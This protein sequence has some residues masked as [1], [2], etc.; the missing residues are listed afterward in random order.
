MPRSD[1]RSSR[2]VL[3]AP[4]VVVIG[5]NGLLP[6]LLRYRL[7]LQRPVQQPAHC[8]GARHESVPDPKVVE[9]FQEWLTDTH[10]NRLFSACRFAHMMFLFYSGASPSDAFVRVNVAEIFAAGLGFGR[11]GQPNLLLEPG[12]T[13][14]AAFHC[15]ELLIQ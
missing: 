7:L 6:L 1:F 13:R 3:T 11:P 15:S 14:C 12:E 8:L 10:V 2:A 4:I 5:S 9:P